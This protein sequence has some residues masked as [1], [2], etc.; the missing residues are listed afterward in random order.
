MVAH[1]EATVGIEHGTPHLFRTMHTRFKISHARKH[2][3]S[4]QL[5]RGHRTLTELDANYKVDDACAEFVR[6]ASKLLQRRFRTSDDDLS[7]LDPFGQFSTRIASSLSCD[8]GAVASGPAGS[9]GDGLVL[10]RQDRPVATASPY[11][12]RPV[13][14]YPPHEREP[15]RSPC[16]RSVPSPQPARK[17]DSER[18]PSSRGEPSVK[19]NPTPRWFWAANSPNSGLDADMNIGGCGFC[20][21]DCAWLTV[22]ELLC[23]ENDRTYRV[24][25]D[26][27]WL[28]PPICS[29][30]AFRHAQVSLSTWASARARRAR[31]LWPRLVI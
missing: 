8:I 7:K 13:H 12:R 16:R 28:A 9:F 10:I 20:A 19:A 2:L 4:Q 6:D 24:M 25:R 22:A 5:D 18:P 1:S 31:L 21:G 15:D 3:R 17:R 14:R 23:R 26:G 11:R 27:R 29:N 30:L